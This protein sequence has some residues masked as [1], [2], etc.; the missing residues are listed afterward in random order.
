[1]DLLFDFPA[2]ILSG[3]SK[4]WIALPSLKNSGFETTSNTLLGFFK[5]II[6]S[7]SS[8]V[9]TGTV[10]L[11]IIVLPSISVLAISSAHEKICDRSA[12]CPSKLVGVP[13]A[14]KI[15]W[16]FFKEDLISEEKDKFFIFL[17][18]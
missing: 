9:P 4:S 5:L 16:D 7:T 11:I 1:M 13:T 3:F 18:F 10:D 2:I 14:I 12:F 8:H 17:V 15:T 6:F